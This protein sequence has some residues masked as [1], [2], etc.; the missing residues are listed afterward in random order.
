M[1]SY[2]SYL[3]SLCLSPNS[4]LTKA[5]KYL[6]VSQDMAGAMKFKLFNLAF[7]QKG[8]RQIDQHLIASTTVLFNH[9]LDLISHLLSSTY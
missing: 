2:S 5:Q 6:Q 8:E 9:Q 3:I 7:L 4:R 1:P